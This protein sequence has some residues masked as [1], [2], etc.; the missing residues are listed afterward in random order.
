MPGR[1]K[2]GPYLFHFPFNFGLAA[3]RSGILFF[4]LLY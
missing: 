2:E 3:L 4:S 1:E